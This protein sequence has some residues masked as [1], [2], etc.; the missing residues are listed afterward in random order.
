ML[1]HGRGVVGKI[2]ELGGVR[3][4]F[5]AL[6]NWTWL[7]TATYGQLP[8]ALGPVDGHFARRTKPRVPTS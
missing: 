2:N 3:A 4:Q 5:P 8:S 1:S 7:N 6:R